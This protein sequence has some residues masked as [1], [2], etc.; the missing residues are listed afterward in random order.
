MSD[1]IGIEAQV[2]PT[3]PGAPAPQDMPA[4]TTVTWQT[5]I[6]WLDRAK[7]TI[8]HIHPPATLPNGFLK[9]DGKEGIFIINPNQIRKAFTKVISVEPTNGHRIIT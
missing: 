9:L 8:F 4:E 6:W 3:Y 7:E 1:E 5:D 2:K